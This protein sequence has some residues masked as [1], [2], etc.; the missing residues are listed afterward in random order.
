M[1]FRMR[2]RKRNSSH[3][4]TIQRPPQYITVNNDNTNDDED[5]NERRWALQKVFASHLLKIS[6]KHLNDSRQVIRRRTSLADGSTTGESSVM[7]PEQQ[8]AIPEEK[9]KSHSFRITCYNGS[10]QHSARE[11]EERRIAEIEN[12]ERHSAPCFL[13][14]GPLRCTDRPPDNPKHP[15]KYKSDCNF[16]SSWCPVSLFPDSYSNEFVGFDQ[17]HPNE[18]KMDKFGSL[19][20]LTNAL[21]RKA[22][23]K[24]NGIPKV[25]TIVSQGPS[26]RVERS[27]CCGA[28]SV[29]E[30]E[31][32]NGAINNPVSFD[33]SLLRLEQELMRANLEM[34]VELKLETPMHQPRSSD[35]NAERTATA[36]SVT[37]SISTH[38]SLKFGASIVKLPSGMELPK[39]VDEL[40]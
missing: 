1:K 33:S 15:T 30:R 31:S 13:G 7:R 34:D 23:T 2:K 6:R 21:R 10:V 18:G 3:P 39:V 40:E 37:S 35:L 16:N 26:K 28:V 36:I 14:D 25:I 9:P 32:N 27:S 17:E 4:P 38:S 19:F 5:R 24:R 20:R 22:D 29:Y 11:P 12:M 8:F